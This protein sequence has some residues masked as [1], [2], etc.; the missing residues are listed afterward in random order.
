MLKS[1]HGAWG[2]DV[3]QIH[4]FHSHLD[5]F[6]TNLGAVSDEQGERFHQDISTMETRYQGRFSPNMIGDYFWTLQRESSCSCKRRAN[7]RNT[8]DRRRFDQ[9]T[10]LAA[11]GVHPA[12]ADKPNVASGAMAGRLLQMS[13]AKS[14]QSKG[15]G[16]KEPFDFRKHCLFCGN[17][18]EFE[19]PQASISLE[20]SSPIS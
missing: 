8:S 13:L 5:F 6:P 14:P 19:G 15:D 12:Q 4:F 9:P 3:T 11:A 17:I 20:A 16:A 10:L 2:S 7:Y 18:C 1:F